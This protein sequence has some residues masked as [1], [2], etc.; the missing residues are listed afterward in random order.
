MVASL[1]LFDG[2][3]GEVVLTK[4]ILYVQTLATFLMVGAIPFLWV[5]ATRRGGLAGALRYLNLEPRKVRDGIISGSLWA[6]GILGIVLA[7]VAV[8][9]LLYG[10][11]EE[12]GLSTALLA[13]IDWPLAALIA[14][15]AG[16]GEEIL[17]R[18]ILQRWI[19]VWGQAIV[20][21]LSHAGYDTVANMVV[22]LGIGVLFGILYKRRPNLYLVI[23]A[24]ALYDFVLLGIG[25]LTGA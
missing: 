25:L 6:V 13:T 12:S 4:K 3:S 8:F 24:H 21:G 17:Y 22:P 10:T 16:I 19:G 14:L 20:F 1:L 9:S 11:P 7:A 5:R 23:V 2:Q 15:S 18:G